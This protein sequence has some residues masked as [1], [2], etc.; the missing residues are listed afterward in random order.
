MSSQYPNGFDSVFPGFPYVDF[1]E[2]V[3]A[4]QANA[5]VSAIQ[6]IETVVGFGAVGTSA[7]PLFSAPY[8]TTYSTVAARLTQLETNVVG[9]L[10]LNTSAGNIQPL[11]SVAAAGSTGLAADA[12]HVH[13][14]IP[15]GGLKQIGEIFMWPGVAATFP[16]G[17]LLC[18]G[19]GISTSTF[20]TLF[21][22]IAY[23]YGG[24][25]ATFN[26]PNFNNRFPIGINTTASSVVGA[27]GGS[28]TITT[29]NLPAHNHSASYTDPTHS[30]PSYNNG[31]VEQQGYYRA[32]GSTLSVVTTSSAPPLSQPI[33]CSPGAPDDPGHQQ[34]WGPASVGISISTGNT[35]SGTAYNQP[36]IGM[37]FLI[38]AQ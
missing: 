20:S 2:N 5:W 27:T 23:N 7:N 9:G 37:N 35:G 38:R 30:H 29:G 10:K 12:G 24:G 19:Q 21:G 31:N 36:Y 11:G 25:G 1:T 15:A 8:A 26:L 16:A 18:N 32:P 17:C 28:T 6:Q 34:N 4:S 3:T 22:I 33:S 14:G 13:T